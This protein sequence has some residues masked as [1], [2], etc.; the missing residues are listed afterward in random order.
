[1]PAI[2][3]SVFY[4]AVRG[5][6]DARQ[7]ENNQRSLDQQQA[8][9]QEAL[10]Q[11]QD[12]APLRKR[13]LELGVTE[14]EGALQDQAAQR[15]LR[16][17]ALQ[18]AVNVGKMTEETTKLTADELKKAMAAKGAL[19]QAL[20][21]FQVGGGDPQDVINSLLKD[22]PAPEG[23][24]PKA[25]RNADGSIS[26][27]MGDQVLQEFKDQTTESGKKVPANEVFTMWAAEQ[28][29]PVKSAENKKAHQQK[30][31]DE[32][33][34]QKTLGAERQAVARINAD[35]RATGAATKRDDA[36]YNRQHT[37]IK[38]VLDSVMKTM[39][40]TNALIAG[41]SNQDDP[42]LRQIIEVRTEAIIEDEGKPV[43]AAADQAI[44]EVRDRYGKIK[45][46]VEASAK[47]L[48]T[49]GIDPKNEKAVKDA[50]AAGNAA[51]IDL[52]RALEVTRKALGGAVAKHL[53]EQLQAPK[54]K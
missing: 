24:E 22:Y 16:L 36:W 50:A 8:I 49:A 10:T 42:A 9:N 51:A 33:A 44:E 20:M 40:P 7:S 17:Q 53:R 30:Q 19:N 5:M 31:E 28:L 41:Y 32:T 12:Q 11:S 46:R 39:T 47:T 21:K 43:R 37:Q 54:K 2:N 4:G 14:A 15:P 52:E 34:K 45:S 35:G 29:D 38:S 26:F 6:E 25:V 18:S 1:M 3:P 48:T 23:K 27:S 13:A